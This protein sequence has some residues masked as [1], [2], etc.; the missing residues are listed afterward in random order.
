M[1]DKYITNCSVSRIKK[2]RDNM[3]SREYREREHLH[4]LGG[5]VEWYGNSGNQ[6]EVSSKN[7]KQNDHIP[8]I[9]LLG[10]YPKKTKSLS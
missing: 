3:C 4:T 1:D 5:N 10:T 7:E 6:Y 9:P 2:T 8:S